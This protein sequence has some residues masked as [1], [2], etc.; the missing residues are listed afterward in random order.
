[1]TIA[2]L[3][4]GFIGSVLWFFDGWRV[5]KCFT[6]TGVKL[7]YGEE[8]DTWFWRIAGR[9]GITLIAAGFVFQLLGSLWH[10]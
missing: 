2:G 6:P 7:G 10:C 5:A 4:L 3:F 8:Y 1:M 9:T